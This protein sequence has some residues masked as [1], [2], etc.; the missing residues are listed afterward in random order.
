[1][2]IPSGVAIEDKIVAHLSSFRQEVQLLFPY[3]LSIRCCDRM[4]PTNHM[5]DERFRSIELIGPHQVAYAW[6][7]IPYPR[8]PR[9]LAIQFSTALIVHTE[10][11]ITLADPRLLSQTRDLLHRLQEMLHITDGN[12]YALQCLFPDPA[13][14]V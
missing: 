7:V 3:D 12:D 14:N 1:M 11:W 9:I 13:L 2:Y 8:R 6:H 10:L 4:I 5:C